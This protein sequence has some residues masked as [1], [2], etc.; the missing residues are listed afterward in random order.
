MKEITAT[1]IYPVTFRCQVMS[2]LDIEYIR[3]Y[4]LDLADKYLTQG[5]V[6]PIIV[7]CSL[8]AITKQ[9]N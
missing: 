3:D 2:D 9:L 1:V 8:D 7:D 4:I 6:K 5:G